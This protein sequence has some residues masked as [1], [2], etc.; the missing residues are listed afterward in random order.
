MVK[1]LGMAGGTEMREIPAWAT[2]VSK[3]KKRPAR[4]S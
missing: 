2:G 1:Y 3:R 4:D